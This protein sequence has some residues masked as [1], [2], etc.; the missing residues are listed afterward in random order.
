MELVLWFFAIITVLIGGYFLIR[1]VIKL[2][3]GC[4]NQQA[5]KRIQRFFN[6]TASTSIVNDS[7]L[8]ADIELTIKSV[9]GDNRYDKLIRLNYGGCTLFSDYCPL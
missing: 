3:T 9:I 5:D 7:M 1:F 4:N 2:Y 6:G 8:I